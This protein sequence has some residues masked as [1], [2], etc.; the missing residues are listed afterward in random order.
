MDSSEVLEEGTWAVIEE[1]SGVKLIL[2]KK[3]NKEE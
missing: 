2:K 3:D 1:I